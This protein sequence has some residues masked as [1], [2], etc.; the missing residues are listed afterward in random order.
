M[1]STITI[2]LLAVLILM[3]AYFSATETAFTSVSK[4]KLSLLEDKKNKRAALALKLLENY[5]KLLSTILIGNNIV[6]IAATSIATVFFINHFGEIGSTISTVVITVAVLI[7]GEITPKNIAKQFP[8]K[9]TCF[10]APLIMVLIWLLTPLNFIFSL[11]NK[12][13]VKITGDN[14][15]RKVTD[16]E[17]LTI[18]EE[19]MEDGGIGKQQSELI[20]SAIEF[21]D[22]EAVD[23]LTPRVDLTGV[24][25]DIT[26]SS[27]GEIFHETGFS[28]IPV[29]VDSIDNIIGIVH[30]KDTCYLDRDMDFS[31]KDY[32]KKPVFASGNTKISAL[33]RT[34]QREKSH[35][36]VITDEYGGTLGV[37]SME[38]ILEELVGEIWDEYDDVVNEIVK[39]ENDTYKVLGSTSM[40]K[41]THELDLDLDPDELSSSTVNGWIVEKMDCVPKAGTEFRFGDYLVQILESNDKKIEEVIF[42]NSPE[43]ESEDE[44]D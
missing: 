38:D 24:P 12:L 11:W 36:A 3:S 1:S 32:M 29:Y 15:D 37:V 28:R 8:E 9:F 44:E 27:L 17:L 19:A 25:E 5:D 4:A 6:N 22:Q 35:L 26:L 41:V 2:I 21:E 40:D 31:V 18:V 30:Q 23:I 7:F 34:L 20:R 13:V 33:L 43:E 10:S 39:L 42:I 16:E 14:E